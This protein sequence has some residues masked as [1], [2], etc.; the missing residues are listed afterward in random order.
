MTSTATRGTTGS[1][2]SRSARRP[3]RTRRT[4]RSRPA[5]ATPPTSRRPAPSRPRRTGARRLDLQV[6]GSYHWFFNQ[7]DERIG[8]PE[9]LLLRQAIS[10]AIDRET[11]NEAVYNGTRTSSTGIV[12]AGIPGFQADMCD[13]CTYDP[14]AAQ[15]AYDE[16]TAAGNSI[17]EPLP[18][19]F[20]AGAG[21]EDV[22][23]IFVDN[24]A[25]IGI[26][27]EATPMPTEDYFSRLA[28]G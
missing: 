15:A 23:A 13:Y 20:N 26:Q 16:W 21:H 28:D 22:A 10:Q 24:L 14:E 4:T 25:A 7:R 1:T 3:T 8:G 27:A 19:Q 2:A 9:N 12:M 17:A 11:I 6:L 18:V 5:S